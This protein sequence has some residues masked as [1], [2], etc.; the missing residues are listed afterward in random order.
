MQLNK[1]VNY[2]KQREIQN[3]EISKILDMITDEDIEHTI[4]ILK[5]INVTSN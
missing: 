2:N 3:E 1:V 4:R 5:N